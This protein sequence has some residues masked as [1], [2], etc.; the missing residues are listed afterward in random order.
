MDNSSRP[1]H[2]SSQVIFSTRPML[3]TLV[4]SYLAFPHTHTH[5]C[6]LHSTYH[7]L[8]ETLPL[9]TMLGVYS[10]PLPTRTCAPQGWQFS[11]VFSSPMYSRCKNSVSYRKSSKNIGWMNHRCRAPPYSGDTVFINA[12]SGQT[13]FCGSCSTKST[14][15]TIN[16]TCTFLRRLLFPPSIHPSLPH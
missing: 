16:A 6:L 14:H 5:D 13:L 12:A 11:P 8:V 4:N 10:L 1:S 3:T 7:L 15:I 2:L 9:F